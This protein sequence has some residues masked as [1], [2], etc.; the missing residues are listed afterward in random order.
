MIISQVTYCF[1]PW[2][3]PHIPCMHT[4]L[5]ERIWARNMCRHEWPDCQRLATMWW[6]PTMPATS[7]LAWSMGKRL[8]MH[9]AKM[10]QYPTMCVILFPNFRRL[11][12]AYIKPLHVPIQT[13]VVTPGNTHILAP[14]RDG[15]L[16]VLGVAASVKQQ[17]KNKHS[18]MNV[19]MR[20]IAHKS[21]RRIAFVLYT[22]NIVCL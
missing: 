4:V 19:W 17:T 5:M 16:A 7:T 12:L 10:H 20:N 13:I 6:W 14:L 15:K 2:T 18:V 8:Q 11:K 21:N 1:P 22:G 3:I 9:S